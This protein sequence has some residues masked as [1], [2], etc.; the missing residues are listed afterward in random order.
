MKTNGVLDGLRCVFPLSL[1]LLTLFGESFKVQFFK[2]LCHQDSRFNTFAQESIKISYLY[3]LELGG[4]RIYDISVE[5]DIVF[6]LAG[7]GT[8]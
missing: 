8:F 4:G 5:L 3:F 6:F 7:M 1:F 2:D